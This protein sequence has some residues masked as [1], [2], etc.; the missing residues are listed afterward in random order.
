MKQE[1]TTIMDEN[2]IKKE[3]TVYVVEFFEDNRKKRVAFKTKT[4]AQKYEASLK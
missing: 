1:I 3:M 4:A 2:G